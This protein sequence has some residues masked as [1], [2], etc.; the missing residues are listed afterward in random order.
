MRAVDVRVGH[1]DDAVIAQLVGVVVVLA[2]AGAERRDERDD[3]LRAHE[4]LEARALD[5]QDLAAQRQDR[6]ELAVAS[7]LGRAAGGIALDEVD[8]AQR[9][10]ALLAVGELARQAHAVE[11]ALA[12]RELARLA[13]GF[14]RPRRVDDLACR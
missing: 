12:A 8:L 11:H 6:L 7:L 3:L 2:E 10:I 5:V 1:D 14:A 9:R 13:R 4:L